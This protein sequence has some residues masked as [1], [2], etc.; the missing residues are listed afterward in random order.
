VT[1]D[2]IRKGVRVVYLLNRHGVLV[3]AYG[4][5][6]RR[7]G[8]RVFIDTGTTLGNVERPVEEVRLV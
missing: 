1:K 3:P 7:R 2:R 5:V 8:R 6:S 4:V